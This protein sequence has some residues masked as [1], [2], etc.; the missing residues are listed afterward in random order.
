MT[1]SCS[2]GSFAT[3]TGPESATVLVTAEQDGL[4]VNLGE[5]DFLLVRL[6]SNP[7]TGY[8]WEIIN[9]DEAIL[10]LLGDPVFRASSSA[11][12][13]GGTETFSFEAISEGTSV[14]RMIYHRSF[15][16]DEEPLDT[17]LLRVV[18]E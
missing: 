14:L 1:W 2:T 6:E 9:N 3:E 7:S 4:Q 8:S 11:V 16:E 13:A 17:F 18:V 5:G 15:E 10:R 12:G